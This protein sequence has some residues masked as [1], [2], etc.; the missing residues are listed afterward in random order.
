MSDATVKLGNGN[1]ATKE[2]NLLAY[3]QVGGK[4]LNTEFTV[5]RGTDATYVGRDGLI[6]Q[7]SDPSPELIQNGDFSELGIERIPSNAVDF[8][9]EAGW[10]G[11]VS[12]S[13]NRLIINGSVTHTVTAAVSTWYKVTVDV[14]NLNGSTLTVT[15]KD[16]PSSS[17]S[18][19]GVNV[20]YIKTANYP[21]FA[22]LYLS[23]TNVVLNSISIKEV[24]PN[25]RW[26]T[27]GS[28]LSSIDLTSEGKFR[29][30]VI[31]NNGGSGYAYVLQS[32]S[33]MNSMY[34][35]SKLYRAEFT[36]KGTSG[37]QVRFQDNSA[38]TGGLVSL[39]SK[40]TMNGELQT[41]VHYFTSNSSSI[42]L[43]VA[44]ETST[45]NYTVEIHNIS[46][47]KI[48]DAVGDIPRID[49]LN[50]PQGHLLLEPQRTNLVEYS[51]DFT[52]WGVGESVVV[53]NQLTSPSGEI[54]ADK[55]NALNAANQQYI[56]VSPTV[57][58]GSVYTLSCFAKKGEIDYIALV[59]LN[60]FTISYFDL[61][62]GTNLSNTGTI[63]S[64]IEDFGNGWY[65]C[66]ST[67]DADTTSKYSGI[68]L[69]YNGTTISNGTNISNGEGVYVW[70]AQL[71]EGSYPTSYIPTTGV[72][73]TRGGEACTGAGAAKDFN[74]VEGV[75]Y[76]ELAGL[77]DAFSSNEYITISDGTND[78]RVGL[79]HSTAS[80]LIKGQVVNTTSQLAI[81]QEN[82]D[83][84][85][86]YKTAIHYKL[87]D[88]KLF[89]NGSQAGSTDTS[90]A[91]FAVDELNTLNFDL[92]NGSST[93]FY[94][95][96]KS[97]QVF[98]RALVD[99]ELEY[100]T[101]NGDL[102]EWSSF[103]GMAVA[104]NYTVK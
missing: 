42:H 61:N 1:W 27:T 55:L 53:A 51:E 87:N 36:V 94:G 95:K 49:F 88:F 54:T 7:M 45:S 74:S 32:E 62:N 91:A 57:S 3:K 38:N 80:G 39:V 100:L 47:K 18:S 46:L 75:L 43:L 64:S 104:Y 8:A 30:N 50:N 9:D 63:S 76:S 5:A 79:Y 83:V 84:S 4:Y 89:V 10:W 92:G 102:P 81:A 16:G 17:I 70:G 37:K 19:T 56:S 59:G 52:Q 14:Y 26:T 21:S 20:I 15:L 82:L 73:V 29:M 41:V 90:V 65:R 85:I 44:R 71:E 67:F 48:A 99:D 28:V 77:T 60:P 13:E 78:N 2:N 6:K 33:N 22:G 25:N 97:L 12:F 98:N 66:T 72:A 96:I 68:Y 34:V 86:F 31:A 24:D 23:G 35:D 93:R 101:T 11:G 69:S 103:E 40:L 58:S